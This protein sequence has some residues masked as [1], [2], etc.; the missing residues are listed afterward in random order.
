MN[1]KWA[2]AKTALITGGARR[3]GRHIA[4]ALGDA[5]VNIVIHYRH[6][7]AE[8]ESLC[9][10]LLKKG[11]K[12]WI[13]RADFDSSDET[14]DLIR[15]AADSA[16]KIDF[17]INNAS[18][19]LPSTVEDLDFSTLTRDLQVNAWSPFMLCRLFARRFG[20]GK[21]INLI[22]TR[23]AGYDPAHFGYFLSK[24]LLL[25]MTEL[26]ALELAPRITVNAVAPGL[27]LPPQGKDETYLEKLATGVPL[28]RHGDTGDIAEAVLF[29]LR[30]DFVTGQVIFVDGG[31]HLKERSNGPYHH[32]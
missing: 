23:V 25:T 19:F 3:I 24:K 28:A 31:S 15:A 16:G 11:V 12:A 21:I 18:S 26:L 32:Q 22:D 7:A 10:E 20:S 8:A 27:I 29:L 9:G 5:G 2:G 30:S 14:P 13:V 4:L 6:S 17:L 1:G